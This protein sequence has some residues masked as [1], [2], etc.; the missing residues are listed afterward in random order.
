MKI[1]TKESSS[2]RTTG[3]YVDGVKTRKCEI[4][5]LAC[6]TSEV[7]VIDYFTAK[8]FH[9]I[10]Y[11]LSKMK[12]VYTGYYGYSLMTMPAALEL[13]YLTGRG[14]SRDIY[15]VS[16]PEKP[17]TNVLHVHSNNVALWRMRNQ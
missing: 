7:V 1:T 10:E 13:G 4:E 6:N 5:S 11:P 16:K 15:Y 12:V 3:Y 17:N 2:G 9:F 14:H 8:Q